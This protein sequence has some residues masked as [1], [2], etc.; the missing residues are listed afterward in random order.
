MDL[1]HAAH[2]GGLAARRTERRFSATEAEVRE[3]E[4]RV[5]RRRAAAAE[6]R[7][8]YVERGRHAAPRTA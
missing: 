6:S 2:A 5:L 7:I 8:V 1:A 4:Q 3:A